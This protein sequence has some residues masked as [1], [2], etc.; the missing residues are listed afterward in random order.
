[1]KEIRGGVK[2]LPSS[3]FQEADYMRRG[4]IRGLCIV[5]LAVLFMVVGRAPGSCKEV[6][7]SLCS[8]MVYQSVN[9]GDSWEGLYVETDIALHYNDMA[10]DDR[11][12]IIYIATGTGILKSTDGGV[13]WQKIYPLQNR[14]TFNAL[15]LAADDPSSLY[16]ITPLYLYVSHDRGKNWAQYPLPQKEVYFVAASRVGRK[17]YVAGSKRI[18][19][20]YDDG[21]SWAPI[22]S[23]IS[24]YA[25][26]E[27]MA[28]NPA[29]SGEIYLT[30]S[31]GLYHTNDGGGKWWTKKIS[32][33]EWVKTVNVMFHPGNPRVI[34]LL[35]SDTKEGGVYYLRRSRDGGEKWF[36]IASKEE[37]KAYGASP[38]NSEEIYYLGFSTMEITGS[39]GTFKNIFKSRDGGRTWNELGGMLP[40]A[41]NIKK[42][43]VRPW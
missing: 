4:K 33:K 8:D 40:G 18:F 11:S 43:V 22:T 42:I 9:G 16:A 15:A 39:V 3:L 20:S 5:L 32:D 17:I 28:V 36:T 21:K 2:M 38:I 35:S 29:D 12:H 27:D 6:L 30:T 37:I 10:I 41:E 25:F 7:Y 13:N 31:V 1:L 34:Y 14:D 26:I 23:N 19:K 24:K